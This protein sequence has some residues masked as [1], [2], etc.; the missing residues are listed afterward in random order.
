MEKVSYTFLACSDTYFPVKLVFG[1]GLDMAHHHCLLRM[2]FYHGAKPASIMEQNQ[3]LAL[4][5]N[6]NFVKRSY[7][8]VFIIKFK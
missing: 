7:Y 4:F 1:S 5:D 8:F 3:L 2:C 6:N